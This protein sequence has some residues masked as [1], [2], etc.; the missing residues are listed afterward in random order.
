VQAE[1]EKMSLEFKS[2]APKKKDFDE[3]VFGT[4]YF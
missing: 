1:E 2:R 4:K 3:K